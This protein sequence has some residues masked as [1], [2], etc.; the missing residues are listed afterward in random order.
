[1]S[2][3]PSPPVGVIETDAFCDG[4]G[5][6]LHTQ[7]VWRDD[8]LGLAVCRCPECGR[9]HAAGTRTTAGNA[10]LRRAALAGLIAWLILQLAFVAALFGG[11]VGVQAMANE[12]LLT[13][14]YMTRDGQPVDVRNSGTAAQYARADI[15][16]APF[17]LARAEVVYGKRLAPWLLGRATRDAE[18]YRFATP[19]EAAVCAAISAAVLLAASAVLASLSWFWRRGLM[20]LWLALPVTAT[21]LVFFLIAEDG[22]PNLT[23]LNGV[24]HAGIGIE[25]KLA[26]AVGVAFALVMALGLLIGRPI[27]RLAVSVFVPP[28]ARQLFAFLWH[29]DGKTMPRAS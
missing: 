28:R 9:H 13:R 16:D 24:A 3:T 19:V 27:A 12:C 5:F 23:Y 17:D 29:C 26:T 1:M 8:R 20:W 18:A 7:K 4:C 14:D 15:A 6:N 2:E 21:L 10:W 22:R 25:I 11:L